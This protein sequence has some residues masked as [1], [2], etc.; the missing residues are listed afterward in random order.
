MRSLIA[1]IF[2]LI[3]GSVWAEATEQQIPDEHAVIPFESRLGTVTFNHALHAQLRVTDCET[4]HHTHQAGEP[5]QACGNCHMDKDTTVQGV[6][7]PKDSK[8]MH[9]RCKGCH[10]YT[11]KELHQPGGPTKCKLCHIK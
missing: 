8:A 5:F 1:V 6:E 2:A 3:A 11:V 10:E 7:V 9:L 4:C